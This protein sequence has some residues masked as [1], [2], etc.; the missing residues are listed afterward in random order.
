MY[1]WPSECTG[2]LQQQF[3]QNSASKTTVGASCMFGSPCWRFLRYQS[4]LRSASLANLR[5]R[6][7]REFRLV[8]EIRGS[9]IVSFP[10]SAWRLR[11]QYLYLAAFKRSEAYGEPMRRGV[12]MQP[13]RKR[14]GEVLAIGEVQQDSYGLPTHQVR[15]HDLIDRLSKGAAHPL[16]EHHVLE[17]RQHQA[18]IAFH[19][20]IRR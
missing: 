15:S 4:R 14:Q 6:P 2:C 12:V 5:G 3:W 11:P 19:R 1:A 13:L 20:D 8:D 9:D 10:P 16:P 18:P 17:I 7:R